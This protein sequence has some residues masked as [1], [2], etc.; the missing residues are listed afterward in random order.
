MPL[1]IAGILIIPLIFLSWGIAV[2]ASNKSA[3]QTLPYDYDLTA[4]PKVC[5]FP[6]DKSRWNG[7]QVSSKDWKTLTVYQKTSFVAEAVAEIEKQGKAKVEIQDKWR[8]YLAL[9]QGVILAEKQFPKIEL[10]MFSFLLGTLKT[11]KLIKWNKSV[12]P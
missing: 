9:D 12:S 8:V 7:Y 6:V 1:R 5:F 2:A 10:N 4:P 3:D 11:A